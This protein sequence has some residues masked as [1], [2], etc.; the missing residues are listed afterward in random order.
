[1]ITRFVYD[2]FERRNISEDVSRKDITIEGVSF[3]LEIIDLT[4]EFQM[5]A[6]MSYLNTFIICFDLSD[7]QS[8]SEAIDLWREILDSTFNSDGAQCK[9][10]FFVGTKLDQVTEV[11]LCKN[12]NFLVNEQ[13]YKMI[14]TSSKNN[15][16]VNEAFI[17]AAKGSITLDIKEKEWK[18]FENGKK[19][20][21]TKCTIM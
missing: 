7:G 3:N 8:S 17:E 14:K 9:N 16:N 12:M 18:E 2:H 20:K 1:M 15:I 21:R 13:G 19:I 4:V 10:I 11:Q 5:K 6:F